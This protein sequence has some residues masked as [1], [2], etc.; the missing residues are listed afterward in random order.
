MAD[1]ILA[2]APA[3]GQWAKWL[4]ARVSHITSDVEIAIHGAG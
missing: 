1:W 4:S 3:F 2:N